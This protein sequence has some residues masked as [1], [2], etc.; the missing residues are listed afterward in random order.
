MRFD[1]SL[2]RRLLQALLGIFKRGAFAAVNLLRRLWAALRMLFTISRCRMNSLETG[3]ETQSRFTLCASSSP[4]PLSNRNGPTVSDGSAAASSERAGLA[5]NVLNPGYEDDRQ[6]S[7]ITGQFTA[8][9]NERGHE[10]Q[11]YLVEQSHGGTATCLCLF[12]VRPQV[13]Y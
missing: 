1:T 11:V 8:T 13:I 10:S 4:S 3:I 2:S 6:I 7:G 12:H 9:V 5:V